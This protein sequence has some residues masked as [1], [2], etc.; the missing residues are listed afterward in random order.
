MHLGAFG[1]AVA[2]PNR[3]VWRNR[4]EGSEGGMDR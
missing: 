2:Q 1:V 3:D 4:K